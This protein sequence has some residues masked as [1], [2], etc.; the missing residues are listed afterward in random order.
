METNVCL[1]CQEGAVVPF[2]D[3]GGSALANAFVLAEELAQA[4][5]KY[6]LRVGYCTACSHV[7][8]LDLVS[9]SE[10][11]SDYLYVSSASDTLVKHLETLAS[12]VVERC[13]LSNDDLVV[14]VGCN[15]GALLSGFVK[16]GIERVLGVDPAENLADI[17]RS[18]GASVISTFFDEEVAKQI[19]KS[20]G[21]A[22]VITMTNTFPHIPDLDGLMRA[23]DK[24]LA[25]SGSLVIEAHYV[26]DLLA[27]GAYDT[28]YHEHVSY[29]ALRPMQR[30]FE[31]V[32]FEVT[33]VQRLPIHHG[34]IRVFVQRSGVRPIDRVVEELANQEVD[35][36][37]G[38]LRTFEAFANNVETNK[39]ELRNLV[40]GYRHE[41]KRVVGYGA[42]AKGNTLLGYLEMGPED[43]DYI[44][45]RSSLK[46]GRFT[47]GTHI[48]VVNPE[49]LLQEQPDYTVLFAWN[50]VEEIF[51][52]QSEY[53]ARGGQF[54]LPIPKVSV[55]S[56]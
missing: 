21:E 48:P 40:R 13:N 44:C 3:L 18:K 38:Q 14:D 1:L 25:P 47:P 34:Q 51:E 50:F 39:F 45:D 31:S 42:P 52:Q 36:G 37:L 30:L 35:D 53:L 15:D 16:A 49:R 46:Q 54:I 6:P 7:Q 29:W 55:I 10:I 17:V 20:H 32:G 19:L 27:Q 9:P 33:G 24:L 23:V 22:S 5:E 4:E 8:L 11:F 41:G 2:L 28:I 12:D 26:G 43:I 56:K